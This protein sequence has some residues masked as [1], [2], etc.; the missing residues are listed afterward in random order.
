MHLLWAHRTDCRRST[1][2]LA[3]GAPCRGVPIGVDGPH[4]CSCTEHKAP[5]VSRVSRW[6]LQLRR[7]SLAPAGSNAGPQHSDKRRT[8][9]ARTARRPTAVVSS[10]NKAGAGA[11]RALAARSAGNSLG[12]SY[13]WEMPG[14]VVSVSRLSFREQFTTFGVTLSWLPAPQLHPAAAPAPRRARSCQSQPTTHT[15]HTSS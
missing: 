11:S 13:E 6:Q 2:L 3:R 12:K 10:R 15:T 14:K 1:R 7:S 8:G 9:R 4:A 5:M